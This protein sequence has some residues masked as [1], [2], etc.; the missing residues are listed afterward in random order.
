[1]DI[2]YSANPN[3]MKRYTTEELRREFHISGLFQPDRVTAT[4]SWLYAGKKGSLSG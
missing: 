3:D 2:R 4:Y 1:M